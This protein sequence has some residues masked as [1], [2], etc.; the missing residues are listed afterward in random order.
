M[1]ATLRN[2]AR[3]SGAGGLGL[4]SSATATPS[5]V[6]ALS[7]MAHRR[8]WPSSRKDSALCFF[9]SMASRMFCMWLQWSMHK[10]T[11]PRACRPCARSGRSGSTASMSPNVCRLGGTVCSVFE[12][13]SMQA[14]TMPVVVRPR[15]SWQ[16]KTRPVSWSVSRRSCKSWSKYFFS[17]AFSSVSGIR[18]SLTGTP[19]WPKSSNTSATVLTLLGPQGS[20]YEYNSPRAATSAI[21]GM[22]SPWRSRRPSQAEAS[23]RISSL[24]RASC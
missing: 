20:Q 5:G 13:C 23:S 22:V 9:W 21:G 17:G 3:S 12:S 7:G 6:F 4:V 1:D 19:A 10:S 8:A 18:Q 2:R 24:S 16:L 11:N 15:P 14:M